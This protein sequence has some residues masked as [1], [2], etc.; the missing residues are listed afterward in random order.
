MAVTEQRTSRLYI[1]WLLLSLAWLGFVGWRAW[2]H[3]PAVPLDMTTLDPETRTVYT[4][5][6][7][8][9]GLS[10]ALAGFGIP[11]VFY[12]AGRL[13]GLFKPGIRRL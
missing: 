9:F 12:L 11:F 4:E 5:A 3:W 6:L 10:A 2:Q 1:L 8:H 7:V 13:L